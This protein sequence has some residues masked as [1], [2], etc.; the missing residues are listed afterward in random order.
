M[1]ERRTG[2]AKSHA[3][4]VD[5]TPWSP[6]VIG[7]VSVLNEIHTSYNR[8]HVV[9]I[10]ESIIDAE[11]PVHRDRLGKLVAGAFGLGRVSEGRLRSIQ[12][13]VPSNY[14]RGDDREFY[15]PNGMGPA[16]WRNVRT[17][18]RG[19]GRALGEVSL[20]EIGNA[21]RVV[22]EKTGGSG[23]DDLKRE[24]LALFGGIRVTKDI[25]A[26]LDEALERAL[27][28]GVLTQLP[29]RIVVVGSA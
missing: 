25:G 16:T 8:S 20:V 7:S 11:G 14:L 6:I 12:Q 19:E 23:V 22:A 26:R 4:L 24:A 15:W 17:S 29:S 9:K 27:T 13:V 2:E 28:V 5:F 21:M 3:D 18:K 10:I 1:V